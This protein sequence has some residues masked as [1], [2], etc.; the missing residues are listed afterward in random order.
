M[1]YSI[2]IIDDSEEDRFL[3]KRYLKKS[4]LEAHIAEATNGEM[5]LDFLKTFEEKHK[6]AHPE[7]KAPLVA[8]LDINMPVMNGWEF[9]EA[10]QQ[11]TDSIQFS[12]IGVI[13]YS[14][15]DTQ[16]EKA[17][18]AEYECVKRYMVKG[19]ATPQELKDIVIS[20]AKAA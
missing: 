8:F 1:A 13:M 2:L 5:A 16:E 15:S 10:F 14:T 4:G 11:Q 12:Q 19:L 9:L 18:I 20:C 3:L 17:R 6:I 7:L